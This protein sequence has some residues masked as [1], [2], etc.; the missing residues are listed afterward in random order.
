MDSGA[1]YD[2]PGL[3]AKRVKE[4]AGKEIAPNFKDF[5]KMVN[6][7]KHGGS[8]FSQPASELLEFLDMVR[9]IPVN[10][11]LCDGRS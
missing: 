9:G 5:G 10:A 2:N 7:I 11:H 3:A 6:N 4:K 8:G 1:R